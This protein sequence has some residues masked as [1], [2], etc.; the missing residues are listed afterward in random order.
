MDAIKIQALMAKLGIESLD[1]TKVSAA[2]ELAIELGSSIDMPTG[3]YLP[4]VDENFY[5]PKVPKNFYYNPDVFAELHKIDYE[6]LRKL[7][8][9]N[10]GRLRD[11]GRL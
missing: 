3:E 7:N 1:P 5:L 6:G 8:T 4:K 9:P 11:L 10:L 2:M